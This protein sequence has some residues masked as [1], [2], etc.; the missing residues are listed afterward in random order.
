[1]V[2]YIL[3]FVLLT[4]LIFFIYQTFFNNPSLSGTEV[5]L[6]GKNYDLEV[7]KTVPQQTKGLMDRTSLCQYCGMIFVFGLDLPQVFWMKNT[8]IP[9]DMIFVDHT[10]LVINI[11]T[12]QPQPGVPDNQLKLYRSLWPVKFVIELNAG[13]A[14]NLSLKTGDT[15]D[16]SQF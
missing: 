15:I 3:I 4:V 8:L 9:L 2:K 13:D 7:A 12:A 11:L 14:Q 6:K 16:L 1:M 5:N 10:G